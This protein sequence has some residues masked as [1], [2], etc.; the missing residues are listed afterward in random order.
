MPSIA[1]DPEGLPRRFS[2]HRLPGDFWPEFHQEWE[3]REQRGMTPVS[4][5]EF[6]EMRDW[7]DG[8]IEPEDTVWPREPTPSADE[9]ATTE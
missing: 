3:F 4:P 2:S 8:L 9:R 1:D 7:S 5:A 6:A